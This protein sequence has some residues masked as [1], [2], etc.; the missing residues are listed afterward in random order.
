M[1][2]EVAAPRPGN[3]T[4]AASPALSRLS[5]RIA[6]IMALALL[7]KLVGF[8]RFQQIALAFGS[9]R[10]ADALVL[11]MQTFFLWD[12]VVVGGSVLPTLLPRYVER[13]ARASQADALDYYLH[14]VLTLVGLGLVVGIAPA[15]GASALVAVLAPGFDHLTR[16][17]FVHYAWF[18]AGLPLA[19]A[20]LGGVSMLNRVHG[21]GLVYAANPVLING[22][23]LAALVIA[24][25]SALSPV[26]TAESFLAGLLVATVVCVGLQWWATP[27]AIRRAI[28]ARLRHIWRALGRDVA[29]AERRAFWLA[30]LP[31]VGAVGVQQANIYVDF[32]FAS[33]TDAGG[34][35]VLGYAERIANIILALT[36][37]ASFVIL[38]PIWA[39]AVVASPTAAARRRIGPDIRSILALTAPL[40]VILVVAPELVVGLI[41]GDESFDPAVLA[42]LAA[43]TRCYAAAVLGL[44][45]AL[46]LARL[47]V[48]VRR[49]RP[50]I[51]INLVLVPINAGLN[52]VLIGPLGLPGIALATALTATLQALA[53]LLV[54]HHAG[55][56]GLLGGPRGVAELVLVVGAA[57]AAAVL[58]GRLPL[59]PFAAVAVMGVGAYLAL[60]LMALPCQFSFAEAV[61]DGWRRRLGQRV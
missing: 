43:A 7:G 46:V 4:P 58:L 38:E 12:I 33:T 56:R 6:V 32:M 11:A 14:V 53:Y 44:G 30:T 48:I 54:L 36:V 31:L 35:A 37:G 61:K 40:V 23:S 8:L 25:Q 60:G 45:L 29:A 2:D 22:L 18:L 1:S 50:I 15:V 5:T 57:T 9:S 19:M 3:G 39:R 21:S 24:H 49:P 59:S 27:S 52:A 10:Y 20:A 55:W 26:R 34:V 51:A 41:Y 13:Q 28:S 17:L 42:T 47:L 16:D